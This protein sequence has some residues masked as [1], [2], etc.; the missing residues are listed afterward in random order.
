MEPQTRVGGGDELEMT[1][2]DA[3]PRSRAYAGRAVVRAITYPAPRLP[4]RRRRVRRGPLPPEKAPCTRG[5]EAAPGVTSR[6]QERTSP[7]GRGLANNDCPLDGERAR[8]STPPRYHVDAST[9]FAHSRRPPSTIIGWLP[10]ACRTTMRMPARGIAVGARPDRARP[11]LFHR[12]AWLWPRERRWRKYGP[13][14]PT[15]APCASGAAAAT[16]APRSILVPN[17]QPATSPA[18]IRRSRPATT[19]DPGS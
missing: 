17:E 5:I 16:G 14:D 2:I 10:G 3:A 4:V 7:G 13:R 8:T 9:N 12:S 1:W 18:G 11:R 15:R 6:T 19:P